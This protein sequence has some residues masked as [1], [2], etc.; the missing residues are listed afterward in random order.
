MLSL[1]TDQTAHVRE[2]GKLFWNDEKFT[3]MTDDIR[4]WEKILEGKIQGLWNTK[5]IGSG[6]LISKNET[7]SQRKNALEMRKKTENKSKY[8]GHFL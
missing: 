8:N 7:T 2:V 5:D 4:I 3:E 1:K 6:L